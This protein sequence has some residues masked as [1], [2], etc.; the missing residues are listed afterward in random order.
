VL[1]DACRAGTQFALVDE[2]KLYYQRTSGA[3][4]LY[5]L[6]G[7]PDEQHNLFDRAVDVATPMVK[8]LRRELA[9]TDVR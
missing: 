7:D 4:Y 1:V 3:F 5:D 8:R 9:Q 2:H 6:R